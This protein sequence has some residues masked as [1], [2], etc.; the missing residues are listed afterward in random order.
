MNLALV[1]RTTAHLWVANL[2]DSR[3][4]VMQKLKGYGNYN[5]QAMSQDHVHSNAAEMQRVAALAGSSK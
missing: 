5:A 4:Y 3:T 1:N 2:G